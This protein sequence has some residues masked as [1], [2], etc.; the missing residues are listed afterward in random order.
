MI[1]LSIFT[2]SRPFHIRNTYNDHDGRQDLFL[3]KRRTFV[4]LCLHRKDVYDVTS[5]F[6]IYNPRNRPSGLVGKVAE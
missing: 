1:D 3:A 5:Q 2:N 6:F 4:L